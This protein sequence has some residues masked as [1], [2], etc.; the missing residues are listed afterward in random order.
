MAQATQEKVKFY[1]PAY[2]HSCTLRRDRMGVGPT[3]IVVSVRPEKRMIAQFEE[4]YEGSYFETDDPEEIEVLRQ[5][6][7]V[8]PYS[9]EEVLGPE[10]RNKPTPRPKRAW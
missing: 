10:R 3:G 5:H 9:I 8:S 2:G 4:A 6:C 1:S 7:K